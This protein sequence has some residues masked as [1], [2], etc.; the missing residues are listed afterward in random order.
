MKACFKCHRVKPIDQ[1]YKHPQ[2]ADGHL[3][4][5]K[6]CTKADVKAAYRAANGR[7]EYERERSQL[8][9]R[10]AAVKQYQRASRERDPVRAK[11]RSAVSNAIRDGRLVRQPCE[12]CNDPKSQAHH[13]DYTKPL[14]VRWLCFRHHREHEHGQTI[15]SA[16]PT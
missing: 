13:H 15:R 8:P 12:V 11:A 10:K 7:A 6:E 9:S 5:C 16:P 4:K 3:N 14:D 1:F 2:M